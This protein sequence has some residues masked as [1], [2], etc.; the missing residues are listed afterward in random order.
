MICPNKKCRIEIDDDSKFCDQCGSELLI[1][2][3]CNNHGTGKF[4]D[5][6][7]TRLES[8]RGADSLNPA[9]QH[10]SSP[11]PQ[12]GAPSGSQN[13]GAGNSVQSHEA[14]QGGTASFDL[15]SE[16]SNEVITLIHSDGL[17]LAVR[18][19]DIL[20]R[21]EG[22]H[23]GQL[24]GFKFMSRRH[25]EVIFKSGTWLVKDLGST[26]KSKLNGELLEP[27]REYP[28]KQGDR[29]MLADQEFTVK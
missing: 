4:C 3:K 27:Q 12:H 21:G 10:V 2:P 8:R 26:N 22:A 7:G 23:A 20:G 29:I 13:Q 1:C 19:S 24:G 9:P 16:S 28:V 25:A 17:E 5:K 14:Q 15:N 18:N 11:A 6:D